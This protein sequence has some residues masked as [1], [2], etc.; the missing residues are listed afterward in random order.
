MLPYGFNDAPIGSR[1]SQGVFSPLNKTLI[2]FTFMNLQR[3]LSAFVTME[4]ADFLTVRVIHIQSYQ[5]KAVTTDA[6]RATVGATCL[7]CIEID[8]WLYQ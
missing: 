5:C 6:E 8:S 4:L 3:I 7:T 2:S 1:T